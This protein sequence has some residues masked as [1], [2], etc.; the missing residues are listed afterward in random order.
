MPRASGEPNALKAIPDMQQL[1]Q[2][3]RVGRSLRTVCL[4]AV[5][6]D[7]LLCQVYN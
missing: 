5:Q 1:S 2:V 7:N 4:S 6:A 3:I